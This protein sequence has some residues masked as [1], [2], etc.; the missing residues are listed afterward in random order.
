MGLCLSDLLD[1]EK[2]LLLE[3]AYFQLP[4]E[5]KDGISRE[6]PLPLDQFIDW[7]DRCCYSIFPAPLTMSPWGRRFAKARQGYFRHLYAASENL[8]DVR[9][10]GY[11]NDNYGSWGNTS[12]PLK[13][14]LV[15]LAY[16]DSAGN[17]VIAYSGCEQMQ[18]SS[19]FL[20]W[21]GCAMAMF[22]WVTAH[23]RRALAFYDQ[24]MAA[25]PGER[26]VLGHS[27]GGNLATYVFINRLE[28][29]ISAYCVNAQPY[30]WFA[31]NQQQR[32]AL[33]SDAFE[34]I[35]H[36][37]DPTKKTGYVSY[38]SR[39]APLNP[40]AAQ[41]NL[42]NIHGLTEAEFDE[43]GNL[44]GART[45]RETRSRLKAHLFRDFAAEARP[46]HD[47]LV[48][49]FR[50]RIARCDSLPRLLSATLD[51][52]LLVTR[53]EA[54]VAW[55][56][57]RDD[58][59]EYIYPLIAKS[60]RAE[61]LCQLKL[62]RGQGSIARC[63]FTGLPLYLH[64]ASHYQGEA[65]ALDDAMGLKITSEIQVPLGWE[66]ED[67]WGALQV[68]NKQEGVF[69]VEDFAMVS[70]LTLA[71]LEAY[72]EAEITRQIIQDFALLRLRRGK[73]KLLTL[74]RHTYLELPCPEAATAQQL[75][76]MLWL[77]QLP[78]DGVLIFNRRKFTAGQ[79]KAHRHMRQQDVFLLA[80]DHPERR[81]GKSVADALAT[82]QP[83]GK[84]IPWPQTMA[85]LRLDRRAPPPLRHLADDGFR[86]LPLALIETRRPLFVLADVPDGPLSPGWTR[87]L[88]YLREACAAKKTTALILRRGQPAS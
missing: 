52:L 66:E 2:Y 87:A 7:V 42:F 81:L 21:G 71:M 76:E 46:S 78:D 88:A 33:K 37:K 73:E 68:V 35:V 17:G 15:C 9:V 59:G 23:H 72:P 69:T 32:Q 85:A 18:L 19:L 51:E 29:A 48:E 82:W 6:H 26:G 44:Q 58:Q 77:G 55:L 50:Q 75:L 3:L 60:P 12:S 1:A 10:T 64:Q 56:K 34:Y 79:G 25:L 47:Q 11:Q 43:F 30:C 70:E 36:A 28:E 8:G 62:R 27:K 67:V 74:E 45:I 65:F 84:D 4:P 41:G 31:M 13:T 86:A 54:A 14:S 39:T 80:L 61:A 5:A 57:D 22:G 40:Y 49:R 24:Q 38:I 63:V 20:D 53:A 83:P 16:A